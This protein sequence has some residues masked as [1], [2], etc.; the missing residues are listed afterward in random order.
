VAAPPPPPCTPWTTEEQV[1]ACCGG[2]DPYYDLT[3]AIQYASEILYRLSGHRWPGECERTVYPCAGNNCG[4]GDSTWDWFGASGWYWVY[5][6]F[7]S[8]PYRFADGWINCWGTCRDG[9]TLTCVDLPGVVDEVTQVVI[10]GEVL[11][12]SA[13]K[14]QAYRR[15]CRVDGEDWP[16]T[17]NLGGIH[18]VNTNTVV[19]VTVDAT[20]GDWSV[21]LTYRDLTASALF[22]ATDTAATLEAALNSLLGGPVVS[23]AGGPGD[24]GGTSPYILEFDVVALEAAPSVT[25]ADVS[26][27]GGAGTVDLTVLEPGCVAD[28]GTWSVSYVQGS[29]PPPGGQ[30]AAAMFACQIALNRCGGDG[31]ILPQRLKEI[32]REG[33]SMA[34]A[35]PMEFLDRGE[36]GIYE[37]DLWLKSVNPNRLQRRASVVRA[38]APKP[39]TNWT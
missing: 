10:G 8:V 33:V 22:D 38:D 37:V 7:P 12:P 14:V 1:R 24:V 25:V 26:L 29:A 34:F 18:C 23:V 30:L 21:G 17:N 4:C 2:L 13:Y 5:A 6:G 28:E 32:T 9:C 16:C 19:E 39:P 27:S 35:D 31:C 36:V 15:I 20:G 11:D 3:D